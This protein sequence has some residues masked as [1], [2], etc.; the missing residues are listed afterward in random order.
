MYLIHSRALRFKS[1]SDKPSAALTPLKSQAAAAPHTLHMGA[2]QWDALTDPQMHLPNI[3]MERATRS[4]PQETFSGGYARKIW[5]YKELYHLPDSFA[6]LKS[7]TISLNSIFHFY[8]FQ[9]MSLYKPQKPV[10]IPFY[11]Y[12]DKYTKIVN[13]YILLALQS[14]EPIHPWPSSSLDPSRLTKLTRG[15]WNHL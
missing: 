1:G 9:E 15:L 10:D 4:T 8:F 11:K 14:T 13:A 3:T 6:W 7:R 5:N 12:F 2:A